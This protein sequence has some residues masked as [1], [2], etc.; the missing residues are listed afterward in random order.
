MAIKTSGF[1]HIHFN[2][3]NMKRF[4]EIMGQLFDLDATPIGQLQPLR[5]FNASLYLN[6]AEGRQPFFDVFQPAGETGDVASHIREHGQG[7]SFISFRVEEIDSAAKH[8]AAFAL[9][10]QS[11]TST[12]CS[13]AAVASRW[14]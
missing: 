10:A 2:V 13:F 9:S 6:G 1:D 12:D 11:D 4:M 8:A 3:R 5:L 7:I 14:M